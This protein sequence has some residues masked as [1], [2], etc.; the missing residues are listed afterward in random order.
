MSQLGDSKTNIRKYD[1]AKAYKAFLNY[2]KIKADIPKYKFK[3]PL[4]YVPPEA[5]LDQLIA[6][7]GSNQLSTFM[8]T[9]KKQ[10][11]DPAKHSDSNGQT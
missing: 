11:Q 7:A 8:Q 10:E 9:L 4:P 3:R 6:S 1:L 2:H 5:L